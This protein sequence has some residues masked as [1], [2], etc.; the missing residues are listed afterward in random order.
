LA[1][2]SHT[3]VFVDEEY[4]ITRELVGAGETPK[5]EFKWTRTFL[6]EAKTGKL[7]AEMTLQDMLLKGTFE[8]YDQLRAK[9][10]AQGAQKARL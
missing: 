4:E 8:G 2:A 6:K 10:N 9:S 3:S 1:A 5:T 7:V